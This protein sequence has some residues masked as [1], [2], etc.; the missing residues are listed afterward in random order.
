M[1]SNSSKSIRLGKRLLRHRYAIRGATG[2]QTRNVHREIPYGLVI[3]DKDGTLT[4]FDSMWGP[5][6]EYNVSKLEKSTGKRLSKDIHRYFNYDT[7]TKKFG[8]SCVAHD[9]H[10]VVKN[11]ILNIMVENHEIPRREAE[12]MFDQ[13]WE[14]IFDVAGESISEKVKPLG[15]VKHIFATLKE[16]SIKTA[17]C[18]SDQRESV[19]LA[20]K[21]LDI[22]HLVDKTLCGNDSNNTPKPA[23][24]NVH[25]ICEELGVD[26]QDTVMVGD[27][28]YDTKMGKNGNCGLVIGIMSG[29]S[30]EIDLQDAHHVTTNLDDVL[31]LILKQK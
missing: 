24:N 26:P 3:F 18:S 23:P 4:S 21:I 8:K 11:G 31:S 16:N 19:E 20:L 17:I 12:V 2:S 29:Q 9:T 27:T 7:S 25:L 6:S 30:D 22:E 10:E 28:Y 5:W 14:D 13:C 15:D 1:L